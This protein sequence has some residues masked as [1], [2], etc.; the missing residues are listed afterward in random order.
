[1]SRTWLYPPIKNLQ[2]VQR[3]YSSVRSVVNFSQTGE[4]SLTLSVTVIFN[5]NSTLSSS[6]SINVDV[7]DATLTVYA[8]PPKNP[9]KVLFF[10]DAVGYTGFDIGHSFWKVEID[11]G[12]VVGT[13]PQVSVIDSGSNV[14]VN[15]NVRGKKFG[16]Y[17]D[18]GIKA[19]RALKVYPI[20]CQNH[21]Q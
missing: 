17:P 11:S 20:K 2:M 18:G 10:P 15:I 5:D 19:L 16:F 14:S 12:L 4:H 9:S 21:I 1:M 13:N 3:V 6:Q 7:V 8:D